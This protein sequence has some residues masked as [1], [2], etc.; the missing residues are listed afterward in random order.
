MKKSCPSLLTHEKAMNKSCPSY[1]TSH[2]LFINKLR[3][4]SHKEGRSKLCESY[5]TT[6]EQFMNKLS[7]LSHKEGGASYV[8]VINMSWTSYEQVMNKSCTRYE[9][10]NNK[11]GASNEQV[12][13]TNSWVCHEKWATYEKA[14]VESVQLGKIQIFK[15][16]S[17]QFPPEG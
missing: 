3:L 4:Q 10:D 7:Q 8:Q 16:L 11:V 2:D 17:F 14:Q 6:Y 13:T 5:G 15:S 12:E 1:G 9:Q